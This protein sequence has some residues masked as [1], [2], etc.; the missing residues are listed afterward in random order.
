MFCPECGKQINDGSKFCRYCGSTLS[1]GSSSSVHPSPTSTPSPVITDEEYNSFIGKNAAKYIMKF[2]SFGTGGFDNFKATWHWPAFFFTFWWFIY[3]KLYLWAFLAFIISLIVSGISLRVFLGSIGFRDISTTNIILLVF[4]QY[5]TT[6][7]VQGGF[8]ISANYIYYKHT[9]KKIAELKYLYPTSDTQRHV[10]YARAGGV[11]TVAVW[12]MVIVL[13]IVLLITMI[14]AAIAIPQFIQY[15]KRGHVST[16][17]TDC[18]NAYTASVAHT[19]DNPY[20]THITLEEV[21]NAGYDQTAGVKTELDNVNGS[22]GTIICSGPDDW[23][24]TPAI[25][26]INESVMSFT[27]SEIR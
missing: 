7:V 17:N 20:D 4:I 5:V 23:G 12:I 15:E 2:K 9:K 19:V 21:K 10:E 14:L 18:K 16:L 13:F 26:N 1:E 25:I 3:R 8:G 11:N 27:P 6:F 22:S 24:V